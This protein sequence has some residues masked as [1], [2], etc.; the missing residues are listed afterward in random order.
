[1]NRKMLAY[2]L[3]ETAEAVRIMARDKSNLHMFDYGTAPGGT[4]YVFVLA[5]VTEHVA[6]AICPPEQMRP[7]PPSGASVPANGADGS[8]AASPEAKQKGK[9]K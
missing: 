4:K 9:E 8:P 6:N 7:S 5:V 2:C 1:M 3:R